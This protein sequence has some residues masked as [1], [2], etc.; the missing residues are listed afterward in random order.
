MNK[1]YGQNLVEIAIILGLVVIVSIMALTLLGK[2]TFSIFQKSEKAVANYNPFGVTPTPANPVDPATPTPNEPVDSIIEDSITLNPDGSTSFAVE[3][4]NFQLS[5]TVMAN[6]NEVFETAGSAGVNE[7]ILAAIQKLIIAHQAEYAPDDVDIKMLFGE[8]IRQDS[9]GMTKGNATMNMVVL[10][11][12]DH[13][14]VIQ[15]DQ[16]LQGF[17][18]APIENGPIHTLEGYKTGNTFE[19]IT[20]SKDSQYNNLTYKTTIAGIYPDYNFLNEQLEPKSA[21]IY[22]KYSFETPEADI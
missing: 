3:G 18:S 7:E 17:A 22:W 14:I 15:K 11:V 10:T 12:G 8:G 21:G 4:Q 2:N 16:Y 9:S 13:M 5:P 1:Y 6:L 19:G 20:S